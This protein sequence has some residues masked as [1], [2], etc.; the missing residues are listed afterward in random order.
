MSL[1]FMNPCQSHED[2]DL[3]RQDALCTQVCICAKLCGAFACRL[4]MCSIALHK[5]HINGAEAGVLSREA[6]A[7]RWQSWLR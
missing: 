5:M 2:Q 6:D 3:A 7:C 4:H 1:R